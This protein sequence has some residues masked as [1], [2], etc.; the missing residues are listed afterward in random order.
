MIKNILLTILLILGSTSLKAQKFF[1]LTANDVRI[2]SELPCFSYSTPLGKHYSDSIYTVTIE[3]PEFIDMSKEDIGKLK[4]LT[5]KQFGKLPE[6]EKS[7][8]VERK[9]AHLEVLFT[10]IVYRKGR[11]QKLVSFMLEIKATAKTSNTKRATA[12]AEAPQAETTKADRYVKNSVLATGKWAKISVPATGV[13]QITDALIKQA[14]FS[15]I[16]KVKIYGYGGTLHEE[17]LS[18]ESIMKYDDLKQVPVCIANGKRLFRANGPV[19]WSSTTTPVRTRNPYSDYGYYFLTQN[20]EELQTV[21]S[22]TFVSS[23]YPANDDYHTLHEVDDYAWYHGGRNLYEKTPINK[24]SSETYTLNVPAQNEGTNGKIYVV[25]STSGTGGTAQI[26]I[27][28]SVVGSIT[29][30][31]GSKYDYGK[32]DKKTYDIPSLKASNNVKITTTSGGPVR[33]DYISAVFNTPRPE[34]Q[35]S[36]ETFATPQFVYNI[37]NQNH[38]ADKQCDMVII[39]PTSQNT[40]KQAER[41]KVFHEQHDGMKVNIVPADELY[42]EFSSGTPEADAYRLYMKMLYDRAETEEEMPKYLLLFGA[43]VWDNRMNTETMRTLNKD[44]YLL[45]FEGENSLSATDCFVDEGF[46]CSLDDGEGAYASSESN[47]KTDKQDIAVGRFPVSNADDAKI[48]VD[49]T[50]SYVENKNAGPW[51]NVAMFLGD[52]GNYNAHIEAADSAACIVERINPGMQVKRVLWDMYKIQSSATGDRYPEV[53]AIIKKQQAEGALIFNYNGHGRADEISHEMVLSNKD[54]ADFKNT[55]LPL[56]ITASCDIMPFDGVEPNIGVNAVLNPNGGSMAFYGTT[57]TVYTDRNKYIDQAY[58]KALFSKNNGKYN[59]IGEAQRIAKNAIISNSTDITR[60]KLHYQLLGDP[61]IVLN[62]PENK[63]V[64]DSING[65]A[66]NETEVLPQIKAGSIARVKGHVET[67]TG[68]PHDKFNGI[69]NIDVK[70]SKEERVGKKNL[71]DSESGTAGD[72]YRYYEYNKTIFCGNDSVK[73]GKFD[74]S[75]A[76]TKDINYSDQNGIMHVFAYNTKDL[77]SANGSTERFIVG[78]TDDITTD[79]IGP[80]IFCYL[81]SP[82]FTNGDNVNTTPYFV[83]EISDEDGLNTSGNG[84]GH[85][86]TLCIDDDPMKTYTL[87]D[88]FSYDFGS[89]TKGATFYN[90]PE[91]EEGTHK[92]RFTAWDIL[93]NPT[94]ETLKF[95]VVKGLTPNLASISCTNNPA[96][97]NTTFIVNH[98][99]GGSNV[100]VLIEVFDMSG[101]LLWSHNESGVSATNTYTYTWDLCTDSGGRLQTGVY[102]YRVRLSSDGSGQVSKAK[103]LIVL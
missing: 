42:N 94:T 97:T 53:E 8:V 96:K 47:T 71:S 44:N 51:Q 29:I 12:K 92:L 6:I 39:V 57:R 37:T 2:D 63:I 23:F 9:Q 80:S 79:S 62:I 88:N 35:L 18:E 86:L 61:A 55:N 13:Y 1:N 78:G 68:T 56:W 38:H 3:Y 30:S 95:N 74:L 99:R 43:C 36:I 58:I 5:T 90:I 101:R 21:D 67:A 11:Y 27:N 100:D 89:Y 48:M 32:V 28:D 34:P 87:N 25:I 10:P 82:N 15:D 14:G 98:D 41:L 65:I 73:A 52:D 17:A 49:K 84:I 66:I 54:F 85:D 59:S 19:S 50:I 64:I 69:I 7:I 46:F 103:K 33:L 24:G 16:N 4:R 93:N 26:E 20:D 72:P 76:V 70:D 81:N 22:T 45:C 31:P 91:L 60:N 77:S 40:I 83:A 75:F 102:L